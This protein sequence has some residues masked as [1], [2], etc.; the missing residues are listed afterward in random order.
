MLLGSGIFL[1]VSLAMLVLGGAT[2]MASVVTVKPGETAAYTVLGRYQGLLDPGLHF[3]A[4]FVSDVVRYDETV[5]L[6]VTEETNTADGGRVEATVQVDLERGDIGRAFETGEVP[7]DLVADLRTEAHEL[8]REALRDRDTETALSAH[9]DVER[10]VARD[11]RQS[12]RDRYYHLQTVDT[13]A[14]ERVERPAV[15]EN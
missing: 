3:V 2:A 5:E 4:P 11:L 8:L 1:F 12:A 14:I 13:L 9:V 6:T 10:T 7:T 15:A